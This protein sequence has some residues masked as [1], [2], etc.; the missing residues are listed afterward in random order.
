MKNQLLLGAMFAIAIGGMANAETKTFVT[1]KLVAQWG[2]PETRTR[3]S[4]WA[5]TTG[6]KCRGLKCGRT[7]WKTCIGHATD[8]LQHKIMAQ[9]YVHDFT[10]D[11]ASLKNTADLCLSETLSGKTTARKV[12][13]VLK[14]CFID[15]RFTGFSYSV[16]THERTEW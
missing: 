1:E 10:G 7:T 2:G 11:L 4:K 8:L 3:C 12:S 14:T 9:V 15:N 5:S 16:S 6:V 13:R